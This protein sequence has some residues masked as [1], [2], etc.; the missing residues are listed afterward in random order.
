MKETAKVICQVLFML[1]IGLACVLLLY[2]IEPKEPP[3]PTVIKEEIVPID[4]LPSFMG[5]TA[6]EGLKEALVYYDIHNY[7]I[8]YAQAILETGKFKSVGC[9]RDNNLFG[10]YNSKSKR[11]HK[12][13]HWAESVIAYKEWIQRRYRPPEDYYHFLQRIGYAEDPQYIN[14]LR[15]IV[16]HE[17]KSSK[18]ASLKRDTTVTRK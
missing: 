10:L 9:L 13:N 4:T 12:F 8:V 11:Y 18:G 7:D 1:C 6:K 2:I 5:K 15:K 14:K 16:K 3:P 17:S